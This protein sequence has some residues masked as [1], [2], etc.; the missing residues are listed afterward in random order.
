[1]ARIFWSTAA[2]AF[3]SAL[4]LSVSSYPGYFFPAALNAQRSTFKLSPFAAFCGTNLIPVTVSEPLFASCESISIL[5]R[6]IACSFLPFCKA[7]TFTYCTAPP[8]R[9]PSSIS[10]AN[11]LSVLRYRVFAPCRFILTDVP[12]EV[13]SETSA[14]IFTVAHQSLSVFISTV[15]ALSDIFICFLPLSHLLT[16]SGSNHVGVISLTV[17]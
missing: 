4:I 13:I 16:C 9:I 5:L 15:A 6:S 14:A 3:S 2:A 12:F 8:E 7:P 11:S 1:M 10:A 17:S